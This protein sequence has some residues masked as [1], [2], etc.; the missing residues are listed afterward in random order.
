HAGAVPDAR[1]NRLTNRNP[2]QETPKSPCTI[3]HEQDGSTWSRR[4]PGPGSPDHSLTHPKQTIGR[5]RGE[6]VRNEAHG[7]TWSGT[8]T[9]AVRA[10]GTNQASNRHPEFLVAGSLLSAHGP[11]A[12]APIAGP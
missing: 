2:P 4:K 8:G 5:R 3:P 6:H 10:R 12:A 11:G 9:R 1:K 7:G